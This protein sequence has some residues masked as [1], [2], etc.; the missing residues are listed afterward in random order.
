MKSTAIIDEALTLIDG[1]R[2]VNY[3]TP[4]RSFSSI[5]HVW[6]GLLLKKLAPGQ[7]I[8]AEDVGLLMTGLKLA[9]EA[10]QHKRDNLVDAHGYLAL[11]ARIVG[12]EPETP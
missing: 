10:N 11:H 6:T 2:Q 3:G 9:R 4:E 8:T 12:C 5:G 7:V 1:G